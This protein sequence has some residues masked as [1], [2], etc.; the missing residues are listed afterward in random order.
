MVSSVRTGL[1]DAARSGSVSV[2]RVSVPFKG[3]VMQGE[4]SYDP[5]RLLSGPKVAA[6]LGIEPATWRTYVMRGQAPAPDDPDLE[7]PVN[8]RRPMWKV[9]TVRTYVQNKKRRAWKLPT[10]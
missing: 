2:A 3:G 8:R 1:P 10:K 5:D 9:S 4:V 7:T 6:F